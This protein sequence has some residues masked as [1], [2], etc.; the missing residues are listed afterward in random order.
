MLSLEQVKL[1]EQ[2]VELAI[3][4]IRKLSEERDS[5]KLTIAEKEKRINELEN[6]V[7]SFKD[8]QN[9]IETGI[10]TTLDL[11]NSLEDIAT[12]SQPKREQP[13]VPQAQAVKLSPSAQKQKDLDQ[14]L[15]K[16]ASAETATQ[17][18]TE[19]IEIY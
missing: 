5:L 13:S 17:Q 15:G 18:S 19:Q 7:V 14:I 4:T 11:L 8:D 9:R 16:T 10:K 6:M 2:K 3:S 12:V 1:L